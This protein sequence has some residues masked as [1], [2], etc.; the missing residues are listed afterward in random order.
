MTSVGRQRQNDIFTSGLT[1]R[2][3]R[4]PVSPER[5]EREAL[6]RMSGDAA[7]YFGGAGLESTMSANRAAFADRRIVPRMLRDVSRRDL[8]VELFGRVLPVP[9]LL[10]PLGVLELAHG[11]ADLAAA[12]AAASRAIPFVTSSQSSRSLEAI[13]DAMGDAP[14]WFQLYWSSSDELTESLVGRAEVAGYEAIVLTLDTTQ[15]GWRPRDLQRGYLPFLRG[16]GLAN[17]VSDPVFRSL[18]LDEG[19]HPEGKAGRRARAWRTALELLRHWP[20]GPRKAL[21]SGEAVEAISR[22]IAYYS[23]P[24]LTW[25]HLPFLRE[26]TRLPIVLKGILHADDARRAVDAGMDGV[27]VSNHGGRQVDGAIAALD[28]LPGVAEAVGDRI[29]VL[30]DSGVRTGA[31]VVKA[32]CL[33]ARAVLLGRPYAYGLALAGEAGVRSVIA[34]LAADLDLTLGLAGYRSVRDLDPSV[35]APALP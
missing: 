17:Y 27:V 11:E 32:V 2:R 26:R 4:V 34:D 10:G 31:D 5:L 19:G 16:R 25:D 1:G 9:F 28:A 15:L 7:A 22:F 23:R 6:K 21:A 13:A 12:R 3:P 35:L 18:P 30:F 8:G 24:D 29:P 20:E 33:G 14:R